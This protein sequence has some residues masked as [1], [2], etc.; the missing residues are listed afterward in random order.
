MLIEVSDIRVG[1][2]LPDYGTVRAI[3]R[4][5]WGGHEYRVVTTDRDTRVFDIDMRLRGTADV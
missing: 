1:T 5:I 2:V 3:A 4:H